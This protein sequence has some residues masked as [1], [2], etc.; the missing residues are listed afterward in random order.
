MKAADLAPKDDELQIKVGNL[1]LVAGKYADA[2]DRARAVLERNPK[3][4]PAIILLGNAVVGLKDYES[5]LELGRKA[6]ELDPDRSGTYR[7]LAVVE[8]LRGNAESAEQAFKRA[9]ELDPKSVSRTS[10]AGE[11]LSFFGCLVEGR[12]D[13]QARYCRSSLKALAR[14]TRWLLCMPSGAGRPRL[15]RSRICRSEIF[16]RCERKV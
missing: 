14:T 12:R 16:A 7:N 3:S 13:T 15:S 11:S 5:A 4:V 6:I 8:M 10:C 2:R 9:I 1:L